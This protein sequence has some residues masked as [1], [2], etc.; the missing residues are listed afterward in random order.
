M[1]QEKTAFTVS[2]IKNRKVIDEDVTEKQIFEVF[3][4]AY[5]EMEYMEKLQVQAHFYRN[6]NGQ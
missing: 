6:F 4:K 5:S 1:R 2:Y 3:G